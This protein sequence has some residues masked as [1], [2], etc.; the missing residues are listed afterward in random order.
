MGGQGENGLTNVIDLT[1]SLFLFS[2]GTQ[3]A[4]ALIFA[5]VFV[6][7]ARAARH[8]PYFDLWKRAWIARAVGLSAI[9][10]RFLVPLP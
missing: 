2:L 6:A 4:L 9:L 8:P 7:L 1:S 3:C 5:V 10:V